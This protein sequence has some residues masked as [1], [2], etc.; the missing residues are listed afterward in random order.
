MNRRTRGIA[1]AALASTLAWSTASAQ[2]DSADST[3]DVLFEARLAPTERA[4]HVRI[5]LGDGAA[6][7]RELRFRVDPE[8][9]L[10]FSGDGELTNAGEYVTWV[11]PEGGGEL[12]YVFRIDHFR[13]MRS[14]DARCAA[15][16]ALFRGDDLVPPARVRQ[17]KG[18]RSRSRLRLR[19]P[20][21][22]SAAVPYAKLSGGDYRVTHPHRAFDRPTGW[23]VLGDI[24]VIRETVGETRVAVAGPVRH[25]LRRLDILAL[26]RWTLPEL[27]RILES[28]PERLLIVGA[29]APMWRGGLSG[30][31]SVYVHAD[32]PL[33]T[34]DGTSPL[35]HEILHA[36]VGAR[37]DDE[38]DWIVE[39]LAE[40]YSIALL[41]RSGTLSPERSAAA[42][43][44]VVAGKPGAQDGGHR[45][46]AV[47]RGVGFFRTLDLR[48]RERSGDEGKSLDDVFRAL[49]SRRQALTLDRL[50]EA[51]AEATGWSLAE[52]DVEPPAPAEGS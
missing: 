48:I 49:A 45:R 15:T 25:G 26:L 6:H 44:R 19:L 40:Y 34:E 1:V 47:A 7:L 30:P 14:Y 37:A 29:G 41:S 46:G 5:E 3:Y 50:D 42:I 52:L 22:W 11:P 8:R 38:F 17:E 12:S 20:Q 13:D 39:G 51:V 36:A 10:E 21:G 33:I 43:D 23:M 9:H 31:S 18:S 2:E 35:L 28:S 16:W 4:A 24:G 27:S 32:R